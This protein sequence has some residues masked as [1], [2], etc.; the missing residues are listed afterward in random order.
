M[1]NWQYKLTKDA[2]RAALNTPALTFG[3]QNTEQNT[4][5]DFSQINLVVSDLDK[6]RKFYAAVL[7]LQ[8]EP[9]PLRRQR[10]AQA[11]RFPLRTGYFVLTQLPEADD[12]TGDVRKRGVRQIVFSVGSEESVESVF[13]RIKAVPGC[14]VRK[15]PHFDYDNRYKVI[16]EDPEGNE[17]IFCD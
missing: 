1:Q 14:T 6:M 7:A 16:V 2:E 13:Q 4:D 9:L 3:K 5:L 8:E 11:C 12:E 17:L 10:D 15:L